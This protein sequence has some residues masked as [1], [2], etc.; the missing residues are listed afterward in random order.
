MLYMYTYMDFL[1]IPM[2]HEVLH[3]HCFP[4]YVLS[5]GMLIVDKI[6]LFQHNDLIR[7]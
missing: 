5:A 7:Y 6:L 4:S 3:H 1:K 2:N